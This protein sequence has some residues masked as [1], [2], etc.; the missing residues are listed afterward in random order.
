MRPGD[1]DGEHD[2][3]ER[4]VTRRELTGPMT[5][6]TVSRPSKGR[7][8]AECFLMRTRPGRLAVLDGSALPLSQGKAALRLRPHGDRQ[9]DGSRRCRG[10][11]GRRRG[12]LNS[13]TLT[14]HAHP[15]ID[16]F[17]E[18]GGDWS[19]PVRTCG[20]L[21]L[22]NEA[23]VTAVF[24]SGSATPAARLLLLCLLHASAG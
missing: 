5:S 9:P 7:T 6:V 11:R 16:D 2:R 4:R 22:N 21:H 24:E 3:R 10:L 19:R 18:A 20:G 13:S 1:P 23:R 17:K 8:R 15:E 12:R 14:G